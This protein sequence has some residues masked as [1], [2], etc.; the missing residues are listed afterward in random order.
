MFQC[1]MNLIDMFFVL[2][3]ITPIYISQ[4]YERR[5]YEKEIVMIPLSASIIS[6]CVLVVGVLLYCKRRREIIKLK[7]KN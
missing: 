6:L 7:G 3:P 4:R 2:E 5:F 1:K